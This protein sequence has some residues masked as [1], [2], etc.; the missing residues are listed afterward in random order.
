M[1]QTENYNRGGDD[2]E[3]ADLQLNPHQGEQI[4]LFESFGIIPSVEALRDRYGVAISAV[5]P[6]G[7]RSILG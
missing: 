4:S 6:A 2:T 3:R 7:G 1:K 5:N